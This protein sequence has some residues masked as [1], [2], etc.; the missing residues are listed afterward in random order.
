MSLENDLNDRP[1]GRPNTMER[2]HFL[3][4]A[5]LTAGLVPFLGSDSFR[6]VEAAASETAD[7]TPRQAARDEGLW[8]EVK[9]AFTVDRSLIN[10]DNGY[11]CPTPRVVTEAFV[12]YIWEQE[13]NPYGVF[14][15]EAR[16]RL[17]TVKQSVARLF[18]S[19]P[20]EIALVR[21]TTEALKT[22]LYGIPLKRGDEVLTTTH[23]YSSMLNAL[24][25]RERKEGIKLVEVPVPFPAG[26]MDELVKVIE[27]GITSRTR[28]ILVSH[29]TYTTGQ[30]FPIRRI[31]DL[32]H[33]HGIEVVVD[34]A[35]AV[36]QL[37]F[38]VS[39]L[40]CD[41]YGTSLHK[42]LSAPKGT[43]LLYMKRE[44]VE[45]IEPLYGPASSFRYN[46]LTSMQKYE[47]VG[48]QPHPPFLAI[49]EAVAFHNAIGPK[50]KEER[51][52]YLKDFW[53]E[54]LRVHP[55]IRLYTSTAPDMS[56]CIAGVGIEG[57]DPTGMRDY[58]WNEHQIR[59]SRGRYD[60]EDASRQWVRITP[61]LYT[62]LPELEFFCEVM[63]D[64]ADNGLPEPYSSYEFDPARMRR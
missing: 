8:R 28:V 42:W 35:H 39:D 19:R 5:G 14:V 54:R 47:S 63:E 33:R 21:N 25:H 12:R 7:L 52:R 17:G 3:K 29:I 61:N 32:A 15:D 60:R 20:D 46:P 30:V 4:T 55:R 64:V 38:E 34:G 2:R 23:D 26:S 27:D 40:D 6:G 16:D 18:G 36:A 49:G 45:K 53:A 48:T 50:R 9:H 44:H 41:Y 58:L 51:L 11:A 31:C 59:T 43:G 24:R 62:T 1:T 37:D 10:L 56:C 22:V 57:A 13:Q